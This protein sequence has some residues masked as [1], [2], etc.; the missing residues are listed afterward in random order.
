MLLQGHHAQGGGETGR[1][2]GHRL[3]RRVGLGQAQQPVRLQARLLGQPAPVV[4]A[5]APAGDHH[6]VTGLPGRVV[7]ALDHACEVDA[8]HQRP[9]L[10]DDAAAG[11]GERVLEV[12]RRIF[13]CDLHLAL[14]QFGLV[15]RLQ[16]GAGLLVF[17]GQVDGFEH[18][19]PFD[20]FGGQVMKEKI[21]PVTTMAAVA[22]PTCRRAGPL[23]RPSTMPHLTTVLLS[24]AMVMAMPARR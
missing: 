20:G 10:D 12:Q 3:A 7:T 5:Q 11:D 23:P 4:L 6:P 19:W 14:R 16:L 2:D 21:S 22:R 15:E 13:D 8:R 18:G 17:L 9:A 1:A 24:T